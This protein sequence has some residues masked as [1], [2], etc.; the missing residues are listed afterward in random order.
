MSTRGL[1]KIPKK[2]LSLI[3]SDIRRIGALLQKR[4]KELGW[5]QEEFSEFIDVSINSI[6]Y[7]EQGRRIPSLPMLLRMT[8]AL[9]LKI[10]LQEK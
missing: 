7:I 4:R 2:D 3:K 1:S 6:K 10:L 5:T 9:E 8:K